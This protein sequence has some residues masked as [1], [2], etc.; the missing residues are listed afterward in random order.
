MTLFDVFSELLC[1]FRPK[2][3]LTVKGSSMA[4]QKVLQAT[5]SHPMNHTMRSLVDQVDCPMACS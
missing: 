3:R 5:V 4:E 2:P 1:L